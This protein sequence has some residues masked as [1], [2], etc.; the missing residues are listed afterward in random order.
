MHENINHLSFHPLARRNLLHILGVLIATSTMEPVI[1]IEMVPALSPLSFKIL[2]L[3]PLLESPFHCRPL[4]DPA[5][6]SVSDGVPIMGVSFNQS[7]EVP[8]CHAHLP[9]GL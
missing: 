2:L 6:S 7:E 4:H 5:G 9:E 3:D 8:L 1:T